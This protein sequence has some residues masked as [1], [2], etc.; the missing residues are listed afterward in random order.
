MP[1]FLTLLVIALAAEP[2]ARFAT[3]GDGTVR[4]EKTGLVWTQKDNGADIAQGAAK[5]YCDDLSFAGRDDWRLATIEELAALYDEAVASPP[6]YQYRG[7]PYPLR[8]DPAFQLSAPG[9]WSSSMRYQG[10]GVAWT[11]FFS[12]GRQLSSAVTATNYQRALCVRAP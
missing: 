2:A 12:S 8:M 5:T 7:K 10:R 9:V 6:T 1:T 11:F 3:A 4:D